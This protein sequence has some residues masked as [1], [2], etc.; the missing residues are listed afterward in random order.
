M[1]NGAERPLKNLENWEK[2]REKSGNFEIMNE[3]QPCK[4]LSCLTKLQISYKVTVRL[5]CAS[6][7]RNYV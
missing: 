6:F 3:W 7:S 1:I 2:V 5:I 4:H